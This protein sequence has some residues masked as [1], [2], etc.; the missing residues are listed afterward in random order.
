LRFR[1][2]PPVIWISSRFDR[3]VVSA[4]SPLLLALRFFLQFQRVHVH[5]CQLVVLLCFQYQSKDVQI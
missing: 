5:V 4:S 1:D 3:S 2:L